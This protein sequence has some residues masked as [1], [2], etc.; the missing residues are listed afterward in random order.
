MNHFLCLVKV[1]FSPDLNN[2]ELKK[3]KSISFVCNVNEKNDKHLSGT[4]KP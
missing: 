4:L 2:Q 3:M 1:I